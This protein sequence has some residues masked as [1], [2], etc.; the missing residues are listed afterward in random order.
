MRGRRRRGFLLVLALMVTIL[1]AVISL[2]LLGVRRGGYASS[3]AV[4]ESAQA[5]NLA[6]AGMEDLRTKLSKDPFFPTGIGDEQTEF[7][8]TETVM[9]VTQPTQKVGSFQVTLDRSRREPPAKVLRLQSVGTAGE[10]QA[11][12][13]RFTIYA[14]LDLRDFSIKVWQEGITPVL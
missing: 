2:G 5:R 12:A 8:Y 6:L 13:A 11:E 1:I 3:K 7:T 9:S 4:L 10:L 14:E